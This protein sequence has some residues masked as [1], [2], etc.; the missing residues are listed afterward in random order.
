MNNAQLYSNV[1]NF[2]STM[3]DN[4]V[5][6][7][8][9]MNSLN[10]KIAWMV[11]LRGARFKQYS[12]SKE[13][14]IT[15]Y[16]YNFVA[17]GSHKDYVIRL[18]NDYLFDFGVDY[19]QEKLKKARE[20]EMMKP[21]KEQIQYRSL[22]IELANPNYT[23]LYQEALQ[24]KLLG[25]SIYIRIG[26]LGDYL[27]GVTSG[28]LSKREL[29]NK[30]K[31]IYDGDIYPNIVAADRGR[32]PVLGM[33]I[34]CLMYSDLDPIKNSKVKKAILTSLRSGM[35]R[36]SFIFVPKENKTIMNY[37]LDAQLKEEA[38]TAS[39]TIRETLKRRFYAIPPNA[40]YTLSPTARA[41]L[42]NY[43]QESIDYFNK[44]EDE[45]IIRIE[46]KESWWKIM[47]L[48]IALGILSEPQNLLIDAKY[49]QQ[50]IDF[51][52]S[53]GKGLELLLNLR[54]RDDFDVAIQYFKSRANS[55]AT[56]ADL[57]RLGV[58]KG[59][60]A[61][62]VVRNEEL[63]AEELEIVYGLKLI[64]YQQKPNLRAWQVME[65]KEVKNER[66]D[67]SLSENIAV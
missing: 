10:S 63:L 50:A 62:W 21:E 66:D 46:R 51:N 8:A 44:Y 28:N 40:V 30:L 58:G 32:E 33:P 47:K 29:Y 54:Q 25:G 6:P 27:E 31:D 18:M 61:R 3:C 37:P 2:I 64:P 67:A 39:I 23:G 43:Q 1:I 42:A 41:L 60:F 57:R 49:V 22:N 55:I 65:I 11:S 38:I 36:R 20:A 24:Q 52:L 53:L 56:R 13:M 17:S 34:Q 48:S 15:Y 45:E 7:Q 19:I 9:V 4:N 5:H 12:N 35:A 59:D 14:P 26:E 16:G